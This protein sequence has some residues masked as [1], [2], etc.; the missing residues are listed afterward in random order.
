M[1]GEDPGLRD[2]AGGDFRAER[3]VGYGCRVFAG[4]A[5]ASAPT[6][7]RAAGAPPAYR[8]PGR[9]RLDVGGVVE[10]DTIWDAALVRVIDDV[11]VAAGATLTIAAG[12]R[13]E[14]VGFD[15]LR[16]VDGSLQAIGSPA[17]P[18][19]FTSECPA[20]WRPDLDTRGAWNG[21]TFANVPADRDS[22]RLRWCEIECA[23]ALPGIGRARPPRV[24]GALIDGMGGAIL[25][26][27]GSPVVVS[28]CVLHRNLAERGGAV[29]AHYGAA[30]LLVNNLFHDNHATLRGGAIYASYS[31][32]VVV[33]AT[34]TA[35]ETSAPSAFIE[36]ACIDHF[37]S[38]PRH[39]GGIVWGNPTTYFAPL[40]IREPKAFYTRYCDIE[41]WLGGEGCLSADPLLDGPS[42]PPFAP[43]AG[44]PAIDAGSAAAMTP[45]LPAR[46]LGGG[47]RIEGPAPD[48]GAYE[49]RAVTAAPSD[50]PVTA[51]L[52]AFPNP[53]NPGTC[54]S[55]SQVEAGSGRLAVHDVAGRR[56]RTLAVGRFSAGRQ[57]VAWDGRDDGGRRLPAGVYLARLETGR[58]V[59]MARLVMAP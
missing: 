6:P 37:H 52:R 2:P 4:A 34:V 40:Q 41:H 51:V 45:W 28:H 30:P 42:E 1:I 12:A 46:D 54:L 59:A 48:L 11:V 58:T 50:A 26:V 53:A 20:D 8:A 13:V 31:Y 19:V 25:V 47:P 57:T 43:Q 33:H 16:V 17:L 32:P 36:T 18:I 10:V 14:F 35:N 44:S 22:S 29:A 9:E 5:A 3:A 49:W 38:K 39:L 7:A 27:G 55:W 23:K 21:L 24:G 15:G 56:V